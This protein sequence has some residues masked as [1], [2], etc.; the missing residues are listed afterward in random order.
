MR[1]L[2]ATLL[3]IFFASRILTE[4]GASKGRG[5]YGIYYGSSA[6]YPEYNFF[7]KLW[8]KRNNS[9]FFCGGS[10][11]DYVT[12]HKANFYLYFSIEINFILEQNPDCRSLRLWMHR[13]FS[14]YWIS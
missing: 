6:N 8:L 7:A 10:I 11:I 4:E 13:I 3:L 5:R 2:V 9:T 14:V 1:V 12:L